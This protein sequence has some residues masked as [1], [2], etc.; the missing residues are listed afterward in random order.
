MESSV[1]IATLAQRSWLAN[2]PV[3]DNPTSDEFC[4]VYQDSPVLLV[5]TE[6]VTDGSLWSSESLMEQFGSAEVLASGDRT[7]TSTGDHQR[8]TP[9]SL[10]DQMKS[11][12][13]DDYVFDHR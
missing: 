5:G 8:F 12:A 11:P 1:P 10:K 3:L 6:P 13:A 4:A 2:V 7:T 9:K